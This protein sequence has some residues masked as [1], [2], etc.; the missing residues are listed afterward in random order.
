ML[1]ILCAAVFHILF[2]SSCCR[3]RFLRSYIFL[4]LVVA[5]V[6]ELEYYNDTNGLFDSY[7]VL[8]K[9]PQ[10]KVRYTNQIRTRYRN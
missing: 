10:R 6:R 9:C 1:Y 3:K 5:I 8:F 4:P 7:A 2:I